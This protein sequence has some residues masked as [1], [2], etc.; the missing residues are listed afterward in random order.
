MENHTSS[1]P[2]LLPVSGYACNMCGAWVIPGTMHIC[3]KSFG[4]TVWPAPT[5]PTVVVLA[6]SERERLVAEITKAVLAAL[7][8]KKKRKMET[9]NFDIPI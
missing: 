3:P 7:E 9:R 6:D 2:G 8:G 4:S 5:Y 1:A